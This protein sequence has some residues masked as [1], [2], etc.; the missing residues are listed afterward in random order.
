MNDA[1]KTSPAAPRPSEAP[2]A[3]AG[4]APQRDESG[5][6]KE[7]L[8]S[9]I[10]AFVL[11]FV[12]RAF[13]I[14]AFVIP[15][16]SMAPTLMGAHIRI[17]S[18]ESG[19]VWPV[20]PV[21]YFPAPAGQNPTPKPIQ[22]TPGQQ[23]IVNDPMTR[24]ELHLYGLPR[25]AGDRILVFKYLYSLY[26]PKRFDVVVFKAPHDPQT[27]YIKRLIG[28][29]GDWVAL[30]DGDV[31][32]RRDPA[33]G[34]LPAGDTWVLPGWQ[35][36]RKDERVQR[37][38]WQ[39]V[40]SS[41]YQPLHQV[42]SVVGLESRTQ[43]FR[44]P[45]RGGAG[46]AI[47]GRRSYEYT[48]PGPTSLVWDNLVSE[49]GA[50]PAWPVTDFY[51][52]NQTGE[53]S[54]QR[55]AFPVSDVSMSA[56]VQAVSGPVSLS[57]IVR[58]RGHEF[59][60]DVR[61]TDVT[62]RMGALGPAGPDHR[63]AAPTTW[64]TLGIG[65]LPR[66]IEPGH[67]ANIEFWHVDQSLQFWAEGKLIA[68]GDY[69]WSPAE[70]VERAVGATTA[71][72]VEAQQTRGTNPLG[73][74]GN[75]HQPEIRWEFDGGPVTLHRVGLK[76]D[77]HYQA[78]NFGMNSG[79]PPSE[80]SRA[81]HPLTTMVLGPDHFFVC[82][83]NSPSS[84]DARLWGPPEPWVAAEI[85]PTEGVVPRDLMIGRAFFVYFPSL[86]RGKS[87]SLPVPDFGRLR[88]IW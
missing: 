6:I 72:I 88:W 25:R 68:R 80:P 52:Y 66:A 40:F 7:T 20:G 29:P 9:V 31:F 75:Y 46:W 18:P 10:I 56:G 1:V 23:I 79:K 17:T 64:T 54:G 37:T 12:F 21:Y 73:N 77:I 33:Q 84:L 39:D 69:D 5:Q 15:T 32:I 8:I 74:P 14:E 11:A 87:S 83:D 85:D 59:R 50:S 53:L 70:R 47:D 58:A 30:V 27:N 2:A 55:T 51:P 82:G 3:A 86:I 45:W 26:D 76:R 62:L 19:Y 78:G 71:Q 60:A 28:L 81:T 67:V 22:G 49:T 4:H 35:I 63:P 36:Q 44:P 65:T 13:V 42:R 48:G 34:T 38:V 57:A 41:E 24:E 16:G 61:G 43:D